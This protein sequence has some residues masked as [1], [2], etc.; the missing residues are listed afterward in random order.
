MATCP[1]GSGSGLQNRV[2]GFDSRRRLH[3][4]SVNPVLRGRSR[5]GSTDTVTLDVEWSTNG[6]SAI[7]S[8]SIF[9]GSILGFQTVSDTVIPPAG[10]NTWRMFIRGRIDNVAASV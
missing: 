5:I 10:A 9:S 3:I 2:H 1:S 4:L 8:D 6:G 7:S